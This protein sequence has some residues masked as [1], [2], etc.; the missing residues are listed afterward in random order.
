MINLP[1][2]KLTLCDPLYDTTSVSPTEMT[3]QVYAKTREVVEEFNKFSSEMEKAIN[4]HIVDTTIDIQEF[5]K[6]ITKIMNDYIKS[7]DIKI[8]MIIETVEGKILEAVELAKP[9]LIKALQ[10]EI[11]EAVDKSLLSYDEENEE[12]IVGGNT[13]G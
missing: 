9:T 13:N 6:S 1:Q 3:A 7:I 5:E 4:K 11:A 12:I 2:W 8:P 10:E